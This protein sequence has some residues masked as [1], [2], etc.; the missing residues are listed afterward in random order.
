MSK[1]HFEL[2]AK[3][4]NSIMDPH[5]R[6]QAAIAVASACKEANQRFD[7]DRFFSACCI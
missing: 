4:I 3:Y 5:A 7:Q 2:L 1:K 6:L